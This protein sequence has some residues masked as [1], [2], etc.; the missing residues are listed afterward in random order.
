MPGSRRRHDLVC[1]FRPGVG[2]DSSVVADQNEAV[3]VKGVFGFHCIV[4]GVFVVVVV[5]V[6][7]KRSVAASFRTSIRR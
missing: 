1:C 3:N 5:V 2:K 4:G 7:M 6:E